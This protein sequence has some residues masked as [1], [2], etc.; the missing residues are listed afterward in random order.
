MNDSAQA[1]ALAALPAPQLLDGALSGRVLVYGSLPPEGRDLDLLVRAGER[2][3]VERCLRDAGFAQRQSEWARFAACTAELVELAD[4]ES[5]DLPPEELHS[6]F[7]QGRELDGLRN[8]VRPAPHHSLLILARRLAAGDG[9]LDEKRHARLRAACAEDPDAWRLAGERA[10]AWG[11]EAALEALEQASHAGAASPQLFARVQRE[12]RSRR[13]RGSP[14][15]AAAAALRGVLRKAARPRRGAIVALSGLDGAGKS[16]Q[17]AALCQTLELL[18]FDAIVVR[19]RISW[20]DWLWRLVPPLKGVLRPLAHSVASIRSIARSPGSGKDSANLAPDDERPDP[21]RAVREASPALTDMWTL[22][23]TLANAWSQWRLMHR[24][25]LR[26]GIVVCDRYT[27]D[28][29]VELRYS[30]GEERPFKPQRSALAK[31][32]PTPVRSY[33]LDV[34]PATSLRRKGEWGEQWLAEHRRLYL[35]EC[36]RLGVT[37]IDGEQPQERICAQIARE[38]WLSSA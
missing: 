10:A 27:L 9:T 23:I 21:V 14:P 29:I 18:G 26:G 28:S 4:P 7:E 32:Y 31:L 15:R 37:V 5:W 22:V 33:F 25:L 20:E 12:R 24:Q 8:V 13:R 30:Y 36:P 35:Q 17:A 16:S 6:L 38:V 19:T 3:I 34:S 1:A 11:A 2:P